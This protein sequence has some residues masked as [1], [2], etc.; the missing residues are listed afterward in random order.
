MNQKMV[1]GIDTCRSCVRPLAYQQFELFK[2]RSAQ[3][4]HVK[5]KTGKE[6]I[7]KLLEL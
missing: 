3:D 2:R 4:L 5:P 6:I 7:E 1:V